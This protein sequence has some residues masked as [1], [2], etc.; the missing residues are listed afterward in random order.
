MQRAVLHVDN[1]YMWPAL[2]VEGTVCKTNMP[3]NTA[4]RG[5][6][7]PQGMLAVETAITHL[8][9]KLEISAEQLRSR[10]LYKKGD[11]THYGM[12]VENTQLSRAWEQVTQLA[13]WPERQKSVEAFN[14]DNKW[15]KRG[16]VRHNAAFFMSHSLSTGS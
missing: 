13:D 16:A 8:A 14:A 6:G 5:F 4:F 1:A 11:I 10:N 2:H 9:H 12:P 15:R 3:S 7:G